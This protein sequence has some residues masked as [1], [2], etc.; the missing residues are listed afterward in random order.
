MQI[1]QLTDTL[2][3]DFDNQ[4]SQ[5]FLIYMKTIIASKGFPVDSINDIINFQSKFNYNWK[6]MFQKFQIDRKWE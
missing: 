1:E 6:E 5:Q 2:N 4:S 3:I